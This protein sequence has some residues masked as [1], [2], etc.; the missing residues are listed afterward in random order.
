MSCD[1][2]R[3]NAGSK[4]RAS[5]SNSGTS[6]SGK[7]PSLFD[8]SPL[9]INHPKHKSAPN[10]ASS[11]TSSNNN[12]PSLLSL[13]FSS[14]THKEPVSLLSLNFGTGQ[15]PNNIFPDL[16][17]GKVEIR[18]DNERMP[19]S[20]HIPSLFECDTMSEPPVVHN[21]SFFSLPFATQFPHEDENRLPNQFCI[22]PSGPVA[23]H[24]HNNGI[25]SLLSP[26]LSWL[27]GVEPPDRFTKIPRTTLDDSNKTRRKHC[28]NCYGYDHTASVCTYPKNHFKR[29]WL[30]N[31]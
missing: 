28:F 3:R 16:P 13:N 14:E 19:G 20:N 4:T 15:T 18:Q 26:D 29:Q 30:L 24:S 6:G 31:G 10:N 2:T 11:N 8:I 7:P 17:N 21:P 1:H 9:K 23:P 12:I 22:P 5:H 27:G 25:P